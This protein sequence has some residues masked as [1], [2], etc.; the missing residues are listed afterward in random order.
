MQLIARRSRDWRGRSTARRSPDNRAPFFK[1][2]LLNY[3]Q[4]HLTE[5]RNEAG[6][7]AFKAGP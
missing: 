1:L 2:T 4:E 7:P 6:Q 5:T 3:C